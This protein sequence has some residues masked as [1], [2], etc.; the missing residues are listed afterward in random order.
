MKEDIHNEDE[1]FKKAYQR[2]KEIPDPEIWDRINAELDKYD[3]IYYRKRFAAW[4]LIAFLILLLSGGATAYYIF[5]ENPK[6]GNHTTTI[7]KSSSNMPKAVSD[8]A[9]LANNK[10]STPYNRNDNTDVK[11]LKN[12][13]AY[14]SIP[15]YTNDSKS[16]SYTSQTVIKD[17][18]DISQQLDYPPIT[19]KVLQSPGT[20]SRQYTQAASSLN[21][22]FEIR[23][24]HDKKLPDSIGNGALTYNSFNELPKEAVPVNSISSFESKIKST[25]TTK[26]SYAFQASQKHNKN[27][28]AHYWAFT[29]YISVDFTHYKLDNDA[30]ETGNNIEPKDKIYIQ[31][32]ERHEFSYSSGIMAKLQFS[33]NL[34]VKTGV[35]YSNIAIGIQPQ[36]LYASVNGGQG[37]AYKFITSSGYAYVNPNSGIEPVAGDS[38]N[39]HIAQH[40][41]QYLGIP[42]M[43]NFTVFSKKRITL[44][45]A[46]GISTNILL[47]TIVKTEVDDIT[48]KELVDIHKLCGLRSVYFSYVADAN[49]QFYISKHINATFTPSFKYAVNP[50]NKNNVVKTYPYSVGIG[51]GITYRL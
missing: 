29:P 16:D 42:A 30:I 12:G 8:Q 40:R 11:S 5:L 32:K 48:G 14:N 51:G 9:P 47:S 6:A 22:E 39:S 26:Q 46:A 18:A 24:A 28:F 50:I 41:L 34:S 25:D 1:H 2:L 3:V 35:I 43:L 36:T 4:R 17:R 44:E 31:E 37:I 45:G 20:L 15:L 49:L 13:K 19:G 33:R 21:K 10:K 23:A 7:N 27:S 38:I